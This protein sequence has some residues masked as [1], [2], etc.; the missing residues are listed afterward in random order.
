[1]FKDKSGQSLIEL[2]AA[3]AVIQIGLFS[4]W[5]L[6]L[7]NY[8]STQES[9]MRIVGINLA[10]EGVEII[11]NKRD[12]NWLKR[13]NNSK[14]PGARE[15][16]DFFM[17]WDHGLANGEYAVSFDSQELTPVD[18]NNTKMYIYDNFYHSGI[19]NFITSGQLTP[20]QRKITINSICCADSSPNDFR[21]DDK[22]F[23]LMLNNEVEDGSCQLRLGINIISEVSWVIGGNQRRAMI[24]EN[25]YD[26]Q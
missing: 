23:S 14:N 16:E 18:G 5:S 1:M 6:F 9:K 3:I 24:E 19:D 10:R 22:D 17:T 26:W 20:Y 21:C 13:A 15:G 2:L 8:N 7:V 4:V 25:L 12:S 11:K